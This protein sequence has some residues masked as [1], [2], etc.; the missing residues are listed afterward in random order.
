MPTLE[1]RDVGWENVCLSVPAIDPLERLQKS[2]PSGL[3]KGIFLAY[4]GVP[5]LRF[6]GFLVTAHG[7]IDRVYG[8]CPI[9]SGLELG[10]SLWRT[11]VRQ[12]FRV[13]IDL[14]TRSGAANASNYIAFRSE[15]RDA[16][17]IPGWLYS[18]NCVPLTHSWDAR[19][20]QPRPFCPKL[21]SAM[22]S[23]PEAR[24]WLSQNIQT[25][26]TERVTPEFPQHCKLRDQEEKILQYMC[27]GMSEKEIAQS[28]SMSPHTVHANIKKIYRVFKVG[29]RGR[30]LAVCLGG[31]L[32]VLR[33]LEQTDAAKGSGMA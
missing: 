23:Q 8:F 18:L 31:K 9:N 21:F 12:Q 1:Q 13:A 14:A 4:A 7:S 28:L 11:E 10:S 29:S 5:S 27:T 30:L 26:A 3:Q 15:C 20:Q 32:P 16:S 24:E 33:S 22:A 6:A 17:G 19:L 25:D 2:L